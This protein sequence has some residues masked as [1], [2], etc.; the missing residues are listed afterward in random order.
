MKYVSNYDKPLN[1]PVSDVMYKRLIFVKTQ[2]KLLTVYTSRHK[3]S[4]AHK[5]QEIYLLIS[6]QLNDL[7]FVV[8]SEEEMTVLLKELLCILNIDNINNI[9][10]KAFSKWIENKPG[11][12]IV[13]RCLLKT[14]GMAVTDHEILS[15]LFE[16]TL[17]S[18]F[19]NIGE[20]QVQIQNN[21][22]LFK[23]NIFS[24]R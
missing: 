2:I 14:L 13:V 4:L 22:D 16:V 5:Q 12:G 8:T 7:E 1:E 18:Y 20:I 17:N 9:S 3:N 15:E 10:L 19:C 24:V 11:N 6:R 21:R 23:L